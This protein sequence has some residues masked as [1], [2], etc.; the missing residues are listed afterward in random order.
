[1]LQEVEE[2]K[3][4]IGQGS[5]QIRQ[6]QGQEESSK[7]EKIGTPENLCRL[8]R[9]WKEWRSVPYGKPTEKEE[10]GCDW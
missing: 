8:G 1:M 7:S 6:P 5:I 3:E 4:E 10:Y 2:N 9:I